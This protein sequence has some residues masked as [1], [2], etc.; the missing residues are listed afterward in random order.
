MSAHYTPYKN[1]PDTERLD[2]ADGDQVDDGPGAVRVRRS[3]GFLN[4]D[5]CVL[6]KAAVVACSAVFC[7]VAGA[8]LGL[9]I[10]FYAAR[11]TRP[12]ILS[13][14]TI[15]GLEWNIEDETVTQKILEMVSSDRIRNNL[16]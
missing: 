9:V 4:R 15:P 6:S 16:R 3:N 8:G 14:S 1:D 2:W 7:L 13:T 12:N 11:A 10:G 5:V